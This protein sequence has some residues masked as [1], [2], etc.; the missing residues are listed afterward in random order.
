VR[1][2]DCAPNFGVFRTPNELKLFSD[3]L[4][5]FAKMLNLKNSADFGTAEERRAA[6]ERV[7]DGP[8]K[9]LPSI[10]SEEFLLSLERNA[11]KSA[12][13]LVQLSTN[14]HSFLATVCAKTLS[15]FLC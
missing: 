12:A 13:T 11:E 2:F 9:A 6:A 1:Y 15:F 3:S 14:L 7:N 4:T 10:I 8:P 5:D